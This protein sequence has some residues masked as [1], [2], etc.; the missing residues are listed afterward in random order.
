MPAPLGSGSLGVESRIFF[1]FP[2]FSSSDGA[3]MS[4][5]APRNREEH[6]G[7]NQV[8]P[9]FQPLFQFIDII[10]HFFLIESVKKTLPFPAPFYP[11]V[12]RQERYPE[13]PSG[14]ISMISGRTSSRPMSWMARK[15][16]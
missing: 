2:F 7:K 9:D 10:T 1:L 11:G 15:I 4:H 8:F 12:Y 14:G 6:P 3:K 16:I 13:F 5:I